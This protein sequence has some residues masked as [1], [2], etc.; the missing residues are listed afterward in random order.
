M[1]ILHV[2]VCVVFFA[3][4]FLNDN[5]R[6]LWNV[7]KGLKEDCVY[8]HAIRKKHEYVQFYINGSEG[9]RKKNF[10]LYFL[11]KCVMTVNV[12]HSMVNIKILYIALVCAQLCYVIR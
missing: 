12:M 11:C 6:G 10:C 3:W 4:Y 8:S 2:C 9:W 1:S 7:N 5:V